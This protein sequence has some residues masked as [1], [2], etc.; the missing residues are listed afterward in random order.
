LP[1]SHAPEHILLGEYYTHESISQHIINNYNP[2]TSI[3]ENH[4]ISPQTVSSL[5]AEQVI[6]RYKILKNI[7][8]GD[9]DADRADYLLRDSYFCGVK[10]GEFDQTRYVSSFALI[11]NN[12][13]AI[14]ISNIHT[15]ESFLLARYWFYMQV[16]FHRTRKGFDIALTQY[17]TKLYKEDRL[18]ETG[19][20]IDESD[21]YVNFDIFNM[22]DDTCIMQCI[23]SDY[24]KGDELAKILM[25]EDH[26]RPIFDKHIDNLENKREYLDTITDLEN[27]GLVRD[28]DFFLYEKKVK[29]H[30]LLERSDESQEYENPVVD[31]DNENMIQGDLLN[32]SPIISSLGKFPAYIRRIYVTPSAFPDAY[33][34][35]QN[36]LQQIRQRQLTERRIYGVQKRST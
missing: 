3:I 29:L 33:E 12:K 21:L 36:R 5:L 4:G 2:I 31:K 14:E 30:K 18:P 19:I 15:I 9:F 13:P 22:F 35:H 34:V 32:I 26:L 16:P 7:I 11:E 10:Y 6:P 24:L 27:K 20:N 25:R 23:K 1:F 8:S 28:S 17:M